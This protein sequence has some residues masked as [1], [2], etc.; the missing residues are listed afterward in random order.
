ML[1][2]VA[3]LEEG[4]APLSALPLLGRFSGAQRKED[5]RRAFGDVRPQELPFVISNASRVVMVQSTVKIC[6]GSIF[7]FKWLEE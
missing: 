1:F 5:I 4:L 2:V 7:A 3:C 6:L